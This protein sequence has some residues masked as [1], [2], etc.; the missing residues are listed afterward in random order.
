MLLVLDSNIFIADFWMRGAHFAVLKDQLRRIG[1]TLVVPAV[2]VAEVKGKFRANLRKLIS[3]EQEVAKSITTLLGDHTSVSSTRDLDAECQK[4]SAH[5]DRELRQLGADVLALPA[6]PHQALVE[7][8]VA[9]RRPFD[10]DG[11][12]YRDAL[13]WES[14]LEVA[15]KR[16]GPIV[17]ISSDSDFIG[18]TGIHED[19]LADFGKLER[20][21]KLSHHK[22]L[23]AFNDTWITPKLTKL[24]QVSKRLS[25][26]DGLDLEPL[27]LRLISNDLLQDDGLL[28]EVGFGFPD[29]SVHGWVD[30]DTIASDYLRIEEARLLSS[31]EVLVEVTFAFTV[32]VSVNVDSTSHDFPPHVMDRFDIRHGDQFSLGDTVLFTARL[33]VQLESADA[34]VVQRVDVLDLDSEQ[35]DS[36]TLSNDYWLAS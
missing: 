5:F 10:E 21:G 32:H 9:K 22:A 11:A 12:G 17:L 30:R 4:F 29:S 8:A 6:V 16:S 36:I 2:V 15:A 19:L 34:L 13:I 1:G 31:G 26:K 24:E 3:D 7:R 35:G 25:A 27:L 18:K 23:V 14:L 33:S 28:A 20:D